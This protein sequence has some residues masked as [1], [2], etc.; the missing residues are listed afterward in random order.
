MKLS[1]FAVVQVYGLNKDGTI[2]LLDQITLQNDERTIVDLRKVVES[3]KPN[4]NEKLTRF[5]RK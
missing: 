3:F 5:L 2:Y 4:E 1:D